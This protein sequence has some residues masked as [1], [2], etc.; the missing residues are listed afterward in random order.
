MVGIG[1]LFPFEVTSFPA[2]RQAPQW[3]E[4]PMPQGVAVSR[5]NKER[6]RICRKALDYI[7]VNPLPQ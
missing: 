3:V 1:N 5:P 7:R 4:S 6:S 2:K